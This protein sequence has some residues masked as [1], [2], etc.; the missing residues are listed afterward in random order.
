MKYILLLFIAAV[1]FSNVAAQQSTIS[2]SVQDLEGKKLIGAGVYVSGSKFATSTNGDGNYSLSLLPG[3]YEI[4]VKM[5]GFKTKIV[6]V[7][8]DNQ[9]QKLDFKLSEE[10]TNLAAITIRSGPANPKNIN[11]FTEL[12][13]GT[14]A[15]A[16]Q[17]KIL[18]PEIIDFEYDKV[19]SKLMASTN[20]F[21]IIENDALGYKIKFIVESFIYDEEKKNVSYKG[22]S[23]FEELVGTVSQQ[24]KW[25]FNR[26][27]AYKGSPRHFFSSLYHDKIKEDGFV[28]SKIINKPNADRPADSIIKSNI[29]RLLLTKQTDMGLVDIT[30]GDSL[31]Y[32][33]K[34]KS[35]PLYFKELIAQQVL[36]D[37]LV[38]QS[39]DQLKMI[40]TRN[41]LYVGYK[42]NK[43]EILYKETLDPEFRKLLKLPNSQV[44]MLML[45]QDEALFNSNGILTDPQSVYFSGYWGWKNVADSLPSDYLPAM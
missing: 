16:K 38:H 42:N 17:C 7:V 41:Q 21:L 24:K 12:F 27:E 15:N 22:S 31:S 1:H 19:L 40:N 43:E 20:D 9:P 14:S 39:E 3:S 8:I 45:L 10:I 11:L 34:Q 13:I 37:T 18:N 33:M 6:K 28:V 2:G 30:K 44:S 23:Y 26:L 4:G 29:K 36:V 35:K 25:N 32:W 5:I